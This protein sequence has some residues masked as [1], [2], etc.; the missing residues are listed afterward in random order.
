[1]DATQGIEAQTL[2]NLYLALDS[3]LVI[4]PVINKIDLP[5]ARPDEVAQDLE[6]LLG[7]PA[8]DIPRI[9]AKDGTNVDQVLEIIVNKIPPPKGVIDTTTAL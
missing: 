3:N 8:T 5:S 1:V 7:F 6:N 9:S 2:A 4:I